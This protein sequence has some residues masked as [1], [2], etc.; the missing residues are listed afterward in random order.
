MRSGW[1]FF[2]FLCKHRING[3]LLWQWHLKSTSVHASICAFLCPM[4]KISVFVHFT[5]LRARCADLREHTSRERQR[6][7]VGE[8]VLFWICHFATTVSV[9]FAEARNKMSMCMCA[10]TCF[11]VSVYISSVR[12]DLL[13]LDQ[14]YCLQSLLQ[15]V[16]PCLGFPQHALPN[17]WSLF[18][19]KLIK[20]DV[21]M[22]FT[23]TPSHTIHEY[24]TIPWLCLNLEEF[25]ILKELNCLYLY[26]WLVVQ[27]ALYSIITAHNI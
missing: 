27:P 22:A 5:N 16:R 13:W 11:A 10:F 12:P 20:D 21:I 23:Y 26:E 15:G 4:F 2:F 1:I 17:T 3:A 8:R 14:Y 24:N 19:S 6:E 9:T 25:L 18:S 7:E